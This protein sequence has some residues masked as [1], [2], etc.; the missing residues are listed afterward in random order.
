MG[1]SEKDDDYISQPSLEMIQRQLEK[2]EPRITL[3]QTRAR[4]AA[5]ST[6][7]QDIRLGTTLGAG[8][9]VRDERDIRAKLEDESRGIKW[10]A[11]K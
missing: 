7:E 1:S 9:S 2:V 11:E 5:M 8:P 6:L 4:V 10:I 3:E